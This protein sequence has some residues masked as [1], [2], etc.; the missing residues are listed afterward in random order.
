MM[1][2]RRNSYV[3]LFFVR[4]FLLFIGFELNFMNFAFYEWK[5][6]FV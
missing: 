1:L 6:V 3:N 5:Q 4:T 2:H